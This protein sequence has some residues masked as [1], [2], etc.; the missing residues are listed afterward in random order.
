M[1]SFVL[2]VVRDLV[3]P[4]SVRESGARLLEK[5]RLESPTLVRWRGNTG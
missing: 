4:L 1:P 5:T 3:V 2:D